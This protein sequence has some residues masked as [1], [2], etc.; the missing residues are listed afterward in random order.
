LQ[1][2]FI[3]AENMMIPQNTDMELLLER[4]HV[5]AQGRIS[6]AEGMVP[7]QTCRLK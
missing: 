4:I 6:P 3:S 7:V 5:S 2:F 1:G